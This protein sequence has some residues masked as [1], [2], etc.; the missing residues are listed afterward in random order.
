MNDLTILTATLIASISFSI[1]FFGTTTP[2]VSATPIA[3]VTIVD[4][5]VE[6]E[7]LPPVTVS[8]IESEIEIE[9]IPEG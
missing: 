8:I 6:V 3:T 4:E 9:Y 1:P 5:E 7:Y 2:E